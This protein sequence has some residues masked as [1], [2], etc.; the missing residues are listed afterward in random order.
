MIKKCKLL[1]LHT[2]LIVKQ[3]FTSVLLI[4]LLSQISWAQAPQLSKNRSGKT[5]SANQSVNQTVTQIPES[6]MAAEQSKINLGVRVEYTSNTYAAG[7]V[8]SQ[9]SIDWT[10]TPSW[11][12]SENW[13]LGAKSIL[14]Q[15]QTG[16]KDTILDNTSLSL[17]RKGYSFSE[18]LSSTHA[19]TAILPTKEETQKVD[20][21]KVGF[22]LSNGLSWS[23]QIIDLAYTLGLGKSVHEFNLNA[24]GKP[25][26][27][28][29]IRHTAEGGWH[30]TERVNLA[31]TLLYTQGFTYENQ[32]R[33]TFLS[34]L[35]IEWSPLQSLTLFVG[36]SNE[37]PA[38]KANGTDS[39]INFFD[40]KTSSVYGGLSYV[41]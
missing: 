8:E 26:I 12:I 4:M 41:F 17:N 18:R 37:G 40:D 10:F 3:V 13:A 28:H 1:N 20:R 36:A 23:N 9:K 21:L 39:N 5:Q 11:K 25:N 24:D 33:Y 29:S 34:D 14:S 2:C 30:V 31:A 22:R 6:K 19:L 35:A 15:Q 7:E 38:L 27:S 16:P 32:S